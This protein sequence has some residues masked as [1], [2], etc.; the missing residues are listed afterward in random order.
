MEVVLDRLEDL[1]LLEVFRY[2]R[3]GLL[4]KEYISENLRRGNDENLLRLLSLR[5]ARVVW[6][7]RTWV[8]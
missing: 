1:R 4:W 7:D 5:E 6:K 3:A 2:P 8:P